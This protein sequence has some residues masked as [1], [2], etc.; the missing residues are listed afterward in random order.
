MGFRFSRLGLLL[1]V[2]LPV[3]CLV[4]CQRHLTHGPQ[5]VTGGKHS[6]SG[7]AAV[8]AYENVSP[9]LTISD[10]ASQVP[11][12]TTQSPA[13]SDSAPDA[14][15]P[16]E[17]EKPDHRL[18][19]I[20][21]PNDPVAR[22]NL[23]R[24][25]L[26]QGML[27][28]ATLELDMAASLD[29][30]YAEAYFLLGRALR[31]RG[32]LD[33]AMAKLGI[34]AKLKPNSASVYVERGICWDQRGFYS[35]GREEYLMALELTPEDAEIYNN[36]G[37]S[38]YLEGDGTAAIKQYKKAL[39]LSPDSQRTN[40]NLAMA[41]G[42]KRD[43]QKCFEHFRLAQGEVTA[44]NNV[45]YLLAQEGKYGE[46]IRHYQRALELEPRSLRALIN[47]ESA[48]RATDRIEEAESVHLRFLQAQKVNVGPSR[49]VPS[50]SKSL[51]GVGYDALRQGRLEG[52]SHIY[53]SRR[54]LPAV[55]EVCFWAV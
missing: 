46:A 13:A 2:L 10:K 47:L 27:P 9:K 3:L 11:S 17:E 35:K 8:R 6:L 18:A 54:S 53:P 36:L 1:L 50:A 45:G 20:S 7:R 16:A 19:V 33:L 28:E 55:S 22:Y 25:Y 43:Y 38:Y 29:P 51:P 14:V 23:G 49:R 21:N 12:E 41:Y 52:V 4:G 26:E 30:G 44:N 5:R 37:Y 32:Q 34:S 42:M 48:F 40:N 39:V 15:A 31:L 24:L